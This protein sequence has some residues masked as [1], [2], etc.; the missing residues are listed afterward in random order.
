MQE[1]KKTFT[2]GKRKP[3][4]VKK[5]QVELLEFQER[6]RQVQSEYP[7][8]AKEQRVYE[9]VDQLLERVLTRKLSKRRMQ[10]INSRLARLLRRMLKSRSFSITFLLLLLL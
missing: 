2:K 8:S 6:L 1:A 10:R 4:G 3:N 9:T 5:S 7:L